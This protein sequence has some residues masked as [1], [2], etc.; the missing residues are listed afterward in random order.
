MGHYTQNVSTKKITLAEKKLKRKKSPP[1][2]G[3]EN[4]QLI[5]YPINVIES[6][7]NRV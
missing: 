1:S 6:D 2:D 4:P 7:K 3:N 5:I